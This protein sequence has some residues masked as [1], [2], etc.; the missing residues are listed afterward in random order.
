MADSVPTAAAAAQEPR[1]A[2]YLLGL[3]SDQDVD[4]LAVAG[5]RQTL[6]PGEVLV[7]AG[8]EPRAVYFVLEGALQVLNGADQPFATIERGELA[9]EVSFID[10]RP[11]TA[12]VVAA[13]ESL[14]FAVDRSHLGPKL[15]RDAGFAARFYRALAA[16][17]AKRFRSWSGHAD[18]ATT[19]TEPLR[20]GVNLHLAAARFE[21]L[22][23]R[24]TRGPGTIVLSGNDLTVFDVAR[25]A[26]EWRRSPSVRWRSTAWR[27]RARWSN[28]PRVGPMPFTDSTPVS[29]H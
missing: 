7:Q 2:E 14:L 10:G 12:T 6:H 1:L 8:A 13:Q 29:A 17:L 18:S 22:L 3:L 15:A 28:A 24:M 5:T 25:V 16:V 20:V 19:A 23:A 4:W 27:G 11:A 9:G 21:R 26:T